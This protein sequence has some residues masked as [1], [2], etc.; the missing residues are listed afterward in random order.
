MVESRLIT[1][2]DLSLLNEFAKQ[3]GTQVAL[4]AGFTFTILTAVSIDAST[5]HHLYY[6]FV[7]CSVLTIATE[8]YASF[9]LSTLAFAAKINPSEDAEDIYQGIMNLAWGAYLIGLITFLS[10]VVVLAWVKFPSVAVVVT[11]I[12]SVTFLIGVLTL[13]VMVLKNN[14]LVDREVS[15]NP[16]QR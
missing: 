3:T 5:P 8:L 12:I 2:P 9:V 16:E 4:L 1:K 6:A 15:S 14:R 7:V 13:M 10:L 11:G